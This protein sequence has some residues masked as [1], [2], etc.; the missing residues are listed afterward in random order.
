MNAILCNAVS[1]VKSSQVRFLIEG[2]GCVT[3]TQGRRAQCS[4][5]RKSAA[6]GR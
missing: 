1:Q 3:V 4:S 2:L 6:S 5:S